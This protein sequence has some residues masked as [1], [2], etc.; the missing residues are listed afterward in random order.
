MFLKPQI[1]YTLSIYIFLK[2]SCS[3]H[4]YSLNWSYNCSFIGWLNIYTIPLFLRNEA[5]AGKLYLV[6]L[7]I[8]Y[9]YMLWLNFI[10]YGI[11]NNETELY[12][13][14]SFFFLVFVSL[15]KLHIKITNPCL[16]V[17]H[18]L[19]FLYNIWLI[20]SYLLSLMILHIKITNSCIVALHI[21]IFLYNIWPIPLSL[22][23][24]PIQ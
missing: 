23:C 2:F 15:M 1:P 19:I 12:M 16:V 6:S 4:F 5:F 14:L 9:I 17:L 22:L 8:L 13:C 24:L 3:K 10:S 18:I 20:S 7:H 11:F 21:L